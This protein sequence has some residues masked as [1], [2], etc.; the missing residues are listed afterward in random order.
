MSSHRIGDGAVA[1]GIGN[2]AVVLIAVMSGIQGNA[3]G[4]GAAWCRGGKA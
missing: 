1:I 2:Y 3:V 4:L